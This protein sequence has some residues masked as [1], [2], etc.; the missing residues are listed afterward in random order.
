MA[1]VL[2]RAGLGVGDQGSGSAEAVRANKI[3]FSE[4]ARGGGG[5]AAGR[6]GGEES[7]E[8][9]DDEAGGC[10]LREHD[11]AVEMGERPYLRCVSRRHR[12]GEADGCWRSADLGETKD[13]LLHCTSLRLCR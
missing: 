9:G 7:W 6:G 11:Q 4:G 8:E 1:V 12:R 3:G 10:P 2:H 13:L 5:T